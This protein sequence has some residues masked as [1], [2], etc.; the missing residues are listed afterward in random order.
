MQNHQ[1]LSNLLSVDLLTSKDIEICLPQPVAEGPGNVILDE[2]ATG[3]RTATHLL[4]HPTHAARFVQFVDSGIYTDP[5]G[6]GYDAHGAHVT[7][8]ATN[9]HHLASTLVK[10]V[11]EPG[12]DDPNKLDLSRHFILLN[13]EFGRSP[14]PEVSPRNPHGGGTDHWPWGYVVVGFGGFVD[15]ERQGLVGSI[16]PDGRAIDYITPAEHRAAMLSAMGIWPF[17][18][19]GFAVGDIRSANTEL[20]AAVYLREHVLG[21]GA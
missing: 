19:E 9:I 18:E 3:L 14:Y 21:Y 17:T 20:D 10:H 11:N 13:T 2:V 5:V 8:S 16:G 6:Q 4:T 7:Q 1:T 15:E 12:E